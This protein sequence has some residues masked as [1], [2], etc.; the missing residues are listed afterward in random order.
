MALIHAISKL[1]WQIWT[2]S[3]LTA[4]Y[5]GC[6]F[7]TEA[8]R[9]SYT[10]LSYT[11]HY[12][13]HSTLQFCFSFRGRKEQQISKRASEW[14]ELLESNNC[15]HSVKCMLPCIMLSAYQL[16]PGPKGSTCQIT[17]R[18]PLKASQQKEKQRCLSKYGSF[19]SQGSLVSWSVRAHCHFQ[20]I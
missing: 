8:P 10:S 14:R 19:R 15:L 11:P 4:S 20:K 12:R 3:L 17:H 1:W 18:H 2:I 9:P 5:A 7:K 6:Y 13:S 16:V